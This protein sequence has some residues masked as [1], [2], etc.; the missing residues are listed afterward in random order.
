[1]PFDPSTQRCESRCPSL[2]VS[3]LG[4]GGDYI[5]IVWPPPPRPLFFVVLISTE[6]SGC[7]PYSLEPR[8]STNA[9][10]KAPVA[11]MQ[12]ISLLKLTSIL[13][14]PLVGADAPKPSTSQNPI[15]TTSWHSSPTSTSTTTVHLTTGTYPL[16]F[17]SGSPKS[18][19]ITNTYTYTLTPTTI[20]STHYSRF[21]PV[22]I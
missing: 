16:G 21:S 6:R 17:Y 1:M 18:F 2:S 14:I 9:S 12:I 22:T 4:E 3:L 11:I 10:L 15:H 13:L 20:V 8:L 5:S 19:V 7:K